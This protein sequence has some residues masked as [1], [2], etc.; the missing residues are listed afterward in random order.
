M[1]C[2]GLKMNWTLKDHPVE[3]L[4][5]DQRSIRVHATVLLEIT[6]SYSG[7]Q[8]VVPQYFM[9]NITENRST[10]R[11]SQIGS[12][13][14]NRRHDEAGFLRVPKCLFPMW[15]IKVVEVLI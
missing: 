15:F 6:T 8:A 1:I 14:M 7:S 11:I 12:W 2:S 4:T 5:T 3:P 9:V 10:P 13:R